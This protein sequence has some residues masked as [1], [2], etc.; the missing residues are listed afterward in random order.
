MTFEV[1]G[2]TEDMLLELTLDEQQL[3][4]PYLCTVSLPDVISEHRSP[5]YSTFLF[6]LLLVYRRNH[7]HVYSVQL[8]NIQKKLFV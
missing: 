4:P 7:L 5:T 3:I 8:N 2:F 6:P 1:V